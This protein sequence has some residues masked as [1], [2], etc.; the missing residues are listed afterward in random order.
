MGKVNP[1][2][3]NEGAPTATRTRDP[4]LRRQVLYPLSYRGLADV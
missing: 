4:L 1:V 3:A 2:P